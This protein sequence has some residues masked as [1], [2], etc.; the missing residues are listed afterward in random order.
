[1]N[2]AIEMLRKDRDEI[3]AQVKTLTEQL[4]RLNTALDA[5]EGK[6]STNDPTHQ[7]PAVSETVLTLMRSQATAVWDYQALKAQAQQTLTPEHCE[8]FCGGCY[9]AVSSL[10]NRGHIIRAPGG[11]TLKGEKP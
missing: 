7:L 8:K 9:A 4:T 3:A 5:L 10:I 2:T 6:L 1:M 11:F